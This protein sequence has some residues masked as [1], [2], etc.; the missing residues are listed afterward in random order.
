MESEE[1]K[2]IIEFE[3]YYEVSNLGRVRS[4]ERRLEDK[5]GRERT[6]KGVIMKQQVHYKGYMM[7]WLRRSGNR[8]KMYVH[9]LVATAFHPNPE[10]KEMV[11]HK[12]K[13][14]QNN[15]FENLEWVTI[16][17]NTYHRD[18]YIPNDDPF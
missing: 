15:H 9:R 17:E 6:F 5:A 2:E 8:Q 7:V 12:D 11:N 14:R 10:D 13:D 1:W 16:E 3:G 4:V 18:N